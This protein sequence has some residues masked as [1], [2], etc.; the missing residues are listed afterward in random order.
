VSPRIPVIYVESVIFIMLSL[1]R[2]D[3]TIAGPKKNK[4]QLSI[5]MFL[6]LF[7][8]IAICNDFTYFDFF[9]FRINLFF[10]SLSDFG[11]FCT[12]L[13]DST[14]C[15]STASTTDYTT[16]TILNRKPPPHE[17]TSLSQPTPQSPLIVASYRSYTFRGR[18]E[19][20]PIDS[21]GRTIGIRYS[22]S[23]VLWRN[24]CFTAQQY[25]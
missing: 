4:A 21:N 18:K 24:E 20:L 9:S 15:H 19:C 3:C 6:V 17:R 5:K 12:E 25:Q 14:L 10:S 22:T 7:V 11:V 1:S 8:C 13:H 23:T 16:T 2:A